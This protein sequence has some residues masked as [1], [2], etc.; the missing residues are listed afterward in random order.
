MRPGQWIAP[1]LAQPDLAGPHRRASTPNVY[2]ARAAVRP[3]AHLLTRCVTST[4]PQYN[5]MCNDDSEIGAQLTTNSHTLTDRSDGD[6]YG[7][8]S[9]RQY[10]ST[11]LKRASRKIA[12]RKTCASHPPQSESE[13]IA[14]RMGKKRILT[15]ADADAN[16]C[17]IHLGKA[18]WRRYRSRGKDGKYEG[19]TFES[20]PAIWCAWA[21]HPLCVCAV[22]FNAPTVRTS[23][24]NYS[25][26][27]LA[28]D[29]RGLGL[30]KHKFS[31]CA[32]LLLRRI[33]QSIQHK[34]AS[35]PRIPAQ[36]KEAR[37]M[38]RDRGGTDSC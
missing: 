30:H 31:D 36:R 24:H 15:K 10:G 18:P 35:T 19:L 8:Q 16:P 21:T 28:S 14:A 7:A 37:G 3:A 12:S 9:A 17:E 22:P 38:F 11:A 26:Q 5:K 29:G 23:L 6:D 32:R 13:L 20:E 34:S 1:S 4:H 2:T 25:R 27:V 33:L